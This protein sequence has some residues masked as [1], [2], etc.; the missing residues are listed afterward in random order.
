MNKF[1]DNDIFLEV[2]FKD[3][4]GH[5]YATIHESEIDGKFVLTTDGKETR[6]NVLEEASRIIKFLNCEDEE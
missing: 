6:G 1:K 5:V 2:Q 4:D 3:S